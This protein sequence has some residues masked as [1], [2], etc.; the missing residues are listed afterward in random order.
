MQQIC[1]NA[2]P[3]H[4]TSTGQHCI[5]IPVIHSTSAQSSTPHLHSVWKIMLYA[6][7][8]ITEHLQNVGGLPK[9]PL[10]HHCRDVYCHFRAMK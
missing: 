3:S 4:A 2:G 10:C 1:C 9:H 8:Q 7:L 5:L 6:T